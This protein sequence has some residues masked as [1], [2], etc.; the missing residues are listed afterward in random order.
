[1]AS[2]YD[3]P[4][5]LAVAF[6]LHVPVAGS[7][8]DAMTEP[9]ADI[10]ALTADFPAATHAQW[11]ALVDAL[12]KGAPFERKLI[13]STYDD[14]TIQPLYARSADAQ[15]LAGRTPGRAW[16]ILQ[17]VDHPDP[18]AAN[19]QARDDC[20]N[21]ADGLSLVFAGSPAAHGYGIDAS[22]DALARALDGI[23]L[24]PAGTAIELDFGR[25]PEAAGRAI[26]S[27][28][29]HRALAPATAS[30]R[31][32]FDPLG[33]M[34]ANGAAPFSLIELR[35]RLGR[36]CADLIGA[37]FKG[38][39]AVADGR[40]I[41]NA[42]G[43]EAQELAFVLAAAIFYLRAL[44]GAGVPV[45]L[46]RRLVFFRLSA[47]ADQFLTT[48]KLRA[49]RLLW[50]RVEEAC[51]LAP[52]PAFVCVETAWRMMTRADPHVNMLRATIAV[53]AASLA[54]ADAITVLPF[55]LARGLPDRFARRMARNT[56]LILI[57]E[58]NLARVADPSAGAG[59]IEHLTA[60]LCLAAWPMF[61]DIERAGGAAVALREG[62]IQA[63]VAA[64]RAKRQAAMATGAERLTGAS[65]FPNLA[66]VPVPVL[67]VAPRS[68]PSPPAAISLEP[69]PAIRLAEPFEQ[70]RE[71]SDRMLA[72]TGAR[73]KIFL[74]N[75]GTPADFTTRATFAK[76]FFEAGGIVAQ[77]ND[78]F[79]NNT[80]MVAGF[81]AAGTRLACLCAS[82]QVYAGQAVAAAQALR[83]AGAL[84]ICLA[85]RPG[86]LEPDL[87]AAGVGTF[88]YA[89]CNM[90]EILQAMY[91]KI[92][93]PMSWADTT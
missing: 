46:A 26:V 27:L 89:G 34:A 1:L 84:H 45:D 51:G 25:E 88:I 81:K 38:P 62:L 13:G 37:G 58:S 19:A 31:F 41:H 63:K 73:P 5:G 68:P 75:L 47:D 61:Q 12:L 20:R 76:S 71:A 67:E 92:V 91:E 69:L 74:A 78:G 4:A 14:L 23:D 86:P 8:N 65:D 24:A 48:A 9:S 17:R 29:R 35:T 60:Q 54:G 80:D 90:L 53:F 7:L 21:G 28:V 56:Q 87:A 33:A 36:V 39:L 66:E 3:W 52:S 82:D 72:E 93:S 22:E 18:A 11:R 57:E 64:V 40:A 83:E 10:H 16:Q 32:G 30:I 85:G 2:G 44:E 79:A 49:L 42:G 15:P 55:T 77:S 59:G 70:L 6:S 50:A 43:S